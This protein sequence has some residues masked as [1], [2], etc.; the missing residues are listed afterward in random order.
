MEMNYHNGDNI[1]LED[2][3]LLSLY[4]EYKDNGKDG[5]FQLS[6]TISNNAYWRNVAD[7]LYKKEFIEYSNYSSY[8]SMGRITQNG[9]I[10]IE[11]NYG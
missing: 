6:A 5:F 8:S 9:I 1:P 3:M 4:R 7:C 2:Q 11:K 10:Y